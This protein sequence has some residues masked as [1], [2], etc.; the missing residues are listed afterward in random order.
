MSE[1]TDAH[2]A[3]FNHA[4]RSSGWD[5]FAARFAGDARMEF[6]GVPIGPF[7]GRD[8]IA[9]GYGADPPDDTMTALSAAS[10][11][12]VDVVRFAWDHGGTGTMRMSWTA[13]GDVAWLSVAFD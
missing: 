6:V 3:A 5:E 4:V 1:R 12:D 13:D 8:A 7:S 9:A 10:D 2:V 11:V